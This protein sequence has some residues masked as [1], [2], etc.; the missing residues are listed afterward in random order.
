MVGTIEDPD[1]RQQL[2]TELVLGEHPFEDL[3]RLSWRAEDILP[4]RLPEEKLS[5]AL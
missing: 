4:K 5:Q 1:V 3:L 2:S